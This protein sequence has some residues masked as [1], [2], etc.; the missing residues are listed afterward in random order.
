MSYFLILCPAALFAAY[1]LI[2][3]K[4][5][6]GLG[7]AVLNIFFSYGLFGFY[8]IRV[9]MI[10]V[11]YFTTIDLLRIFQPVGG[12]GGIAILP[13]TIVYIYWL[14]TG[15]IKFKR[16]M[17][18]I[19][20]NII[21]ILIYWFCY[22]IYQCIFSIWLSAKKKQFLAHT[23]LQ[24]TYGNLISGITLKNSGKTLQSMS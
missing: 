5:M 24:S 14:I 21:W 16:F 19:P 13:V 20:I 11:R 1:V 23:S 12:L 22:L 2:K 10:C 15:K 9:T 3:H 17:V 7:L 8:D 6:Y 4:K 18:E